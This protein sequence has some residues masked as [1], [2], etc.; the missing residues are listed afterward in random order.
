MSYFVSK[1]DQISIR[2]PISLD[3]KKNHMKKTYGLKSVVVYSYGIS[4]VVCQKLAKLVNIC[5]NYEFFVSK[6]YLSIP[7]F[8]IKTDEGMF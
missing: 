2:K 7:N 3:V 5:S 6:L 4:L 8:P 1:M